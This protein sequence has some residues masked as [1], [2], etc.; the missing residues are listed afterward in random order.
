MSE[1][2]A[3]EIKDAILAEQRMQRS[4]GVV[5]IAYVHDNEV[6]HSWHM[7]LMQ[8]LG[9][10]M[11]GGCS[12]TL[13]AW[14][15]MRCGTDAL[16][17][18]RNK[19]IAEFLDNK[20]SEWLLWLDTD[21]G[22]EPTLLDS[23]LEVASAEERP[24]VG[25][26]AF[27]WKEIGPDGMGG[28]RCTPRPVV[29]DWQTVGEES[30]FLGRS[31]YPVNSLIQCGATGSAAILIHRTA[32]ERVRKEFGD[33]WYTRTP[34]PST[35][36]N[37]MGEDISFCVRLAAL[38]IPLYVHT[39]VRTSHHKS[40][41]ISEP[42]FW[43]TIIAPPAPSSVRVLVQADSGERAEKFMQSLRASTGFATVT[44]ATTCGDSQWADAGAEDVILLARDM[45]R[46]EQ[47]NY[48]FDNTSVEEN[49]WVVVAHDGMD[50]RPGWL[51]QAM[52]VATERNASVVGLLD[53]SDPSTMT[54]GR[55][56]ALLIRRDYVIK[57]GGDFSRTPGILAPVDVYTANAWPMDEVGLLARLRGEFGMAYGSVVASIDPSVYT[58][59]G[60]DEVLLQKRFQEIAPRIASEGSDV[61]MTRGQ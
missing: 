57:R 36:G 26:L 39:G 46:A 31:T 24:V 6:S 27:S 7:S 60:D 49:D 17:D 58:M 8:L 54:G 19:S 51:D 37:L 42:D 47:I 35:G 41:W 12:H 32:L 5:S 18:A 30:G 1:S 48:L 28:Y 45:T 22:F 29:L 9:H 52:H 15:A 55:A 38:G 11:Q 14:L 4:R 13:G 21:M 34:N 40:V 56:S 53:T 44:V 50:F 59:E 16:S 10:E 23:L 20:D 25:A 61:M 43:S 2:K 33:N 3:R